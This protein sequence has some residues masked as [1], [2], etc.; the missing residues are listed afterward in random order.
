MVGKPHQ[1]AQEKQFNLGTVGPLQKSSR[2]LL[3][4]KGHLEEGREMM[5]TEADQWPGKARILT[6]QKQATTGYIEFEE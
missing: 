1:A 3:C 6:E 5:G 2:R 4:S